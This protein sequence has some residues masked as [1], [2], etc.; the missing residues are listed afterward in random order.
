MMSDMLH[1]VVAWIGATPYATWIGSSTNRIA[2]LFTFHLFGLILLFGGMILL[3]LRSLNLVLRDVPLQETARQVLP[4]S[5]TGL[6]IMLASGFTIFAGGAT[7]Y[8]EGPF[9]RAKMI[10]LIVAVAFHFAVFGR[11]AVADQGRFS[12]FAHG[13]VAVFTLL[14]WLSVA[15]AGRAIA[16]F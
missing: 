6:V 15:V 13:A 14:L 10:L 1:D 8:F 2:W 3:T 7:S 11:V 4:I 5:T 9:F 12:P 16:F